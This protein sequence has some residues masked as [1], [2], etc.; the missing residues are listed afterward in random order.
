[1]PVEAPDRVLQDTDRAYQAHQRAG[2]TTNELLN[3][4][5]LGSRPQSKWGSWWSAKQLDLPMTY[6]ATDIK[7]SPLS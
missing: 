1:M 5:A 7:R 4:D 3:H 6:A 2:A